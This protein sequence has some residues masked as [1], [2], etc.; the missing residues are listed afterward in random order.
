MLQRQLHRR[1]AVEHKQENQLTQPV[2][3]RFEPADKKRNRLS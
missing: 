2:E 3:A 1:M